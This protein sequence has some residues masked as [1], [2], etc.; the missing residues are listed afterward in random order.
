M[1][2]D[3]K[4][5]NRSARSLP[6]LKIRAGH[7]AEIQ[8]CSQSVLWLKTHW[9]GRQ[10]ICP[11]PACPMC[12][13]AEGRA[14]G[15][16]TV[17]LRTGQRPRPYLLEVSPPSWERLISLAKM[18]QLEVG[19][20]LICTASRRKP[21]SPLTIE[22]FG[23]SENIPTAEASIRRTLDAVSILYGLPVM[24]PAETQEQWAARSIPL[25]CSMIGQAIAQS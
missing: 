14:H 3:P 16:V 13:G 5:L 20:G 21:K 12:G 15:Y 19:T 24:R 4:N 17:I 11:G 7:E 18:E 9:L 23:R 22:P 8:I 2:C 25:A 1:I 6:M 10:L